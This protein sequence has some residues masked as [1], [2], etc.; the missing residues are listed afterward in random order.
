[1]QRRYYLPGRHDM[2]LINTLHMFRELIMPIR[3]R[4]RITLLA[5]RQR[6][7]AARIVRDLPRKH[8]L[9]VLVALDD[10]RG[11]RLELLDDRAVREE[12]VVVP[13][14]SE[15]ADVGVDAACEYS[16][17]KAVCEQTCAAQRRSEMA[18]AV[19]TQNA[20]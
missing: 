13:V 12:F 6:R 7:R 20:P 14:A 2:V 10:L 17:P 1:M 19:K 16:G 8:R 18:M 15:L 3:D 9:A 11:V 5:R 4:Q